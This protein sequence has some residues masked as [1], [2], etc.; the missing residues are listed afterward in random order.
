MHFNTLRPLRIL[1]DLF[2]RNRLVVSFFLVL[3]FGALVGV[4]AGAFLALMRDMPQVRSLEEFNPSAVTRIYA[5]DKTLLA[6]FFVEK[7]VPVSLDAIPKELKDAVIATEDTHF[8]KHA[9][10]DI[11]GIIR[12]LIKD[13][14]ARRFVEGASTITQ[15]LAKTLFL[16]SRKTILRKAKEALLAVQIERCYTK[17]EILELYLNQ[18]YLGSGAYGVEAAANVYFAKPVQDLTL[19]ECAL[20][21]GLPKSPSRYSPLVNKDL[22]LK[23]RSVVLKRMRQTG[24]I[25]DT[26][27]QQARDAPLLLAEAKKRRRKAPYFVEYVRAFLE[28]VLGRKALYEKGLTVY[29]TLDSAKQYAAEKAL[30]AGLEALEK[31]QNTEDGK[32]EKH[33]EGALICLNAHQGSILAMVGGR[34]FAESP[35]NRATQ[36]L[37]QPGSAFKPVVY[38]Y[39]IERGFAQNDTIWDGPVVFKGG[40]RE[41]NWTPANFSGE[42]K[43]EMTLRWALAVSENIPAVKLL[44]KLGVESVIRFARNMGITSP[45]RSNLTLA[46]GTSEVTLLELTSAYSVFPNQGVRVKPCAVIEVLDS[47]G[48]VLWKMK[49]ARR[50]VMSKE[51]AYIVTDMLRGVVQNGTGRK[52]RGIRRPLGGKTGT[53]NAYRDALFVGF[54]PSLTSGVWIGYDNHDSLGDLETGGRA[55]LPIWVDFMEEVLTGVPYQDFAAPQNTVMA[56]IDRESGELAS[57]DCLFAEDAAFIKGTEPKGR[58]R[59]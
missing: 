21:A 40:G 59:H 15:Q 17:D 35:F 37:R 36:A 4:G 22:A 8:Y 32:E 30:K 53:T 55:A 3:M 16:T 45:L 13:I 34:D 39:A 19:P 14:M 6:E 25:S 9:G 51:T 43:G 33:P 27:Y 11:K 31:R 48:R 52:A 49:P 44:N 5:Q 18:I 56:P 28:D 1:G 23:R 54:S 2:K 20:I 26:E 7:R 24:R 29:T 41:E 57:E 46:L 47:N 10:V 42:Y 38:S 12:A 58:G 50:T